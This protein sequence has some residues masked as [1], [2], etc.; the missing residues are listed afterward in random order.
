MSFSS[1]LTLENKI[2]ARAAALQTAVHGRQGQLVSPSKDAYLQAL[3]SLYN[4]YFFRE[5]FFTFCADENPLAAYRLFQK[6][7]VPVTSR[8]TVLSASQSLIEILL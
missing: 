5:N 7:R 4:A 6:T 3:L 1:K 2:F 8:P